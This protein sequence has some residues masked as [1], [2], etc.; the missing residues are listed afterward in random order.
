MGDMKG[1]YRVL[2]QRPDGNRSLGRPRHRWKDNIITGLQVGWG[3]MD[4]TD[5]VQESDKW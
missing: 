5:L 4:W 1:A 2:V 3:G